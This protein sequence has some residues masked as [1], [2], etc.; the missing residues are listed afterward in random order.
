[1]HRIIARNL[2]RLAAVAAIAALSACMVTE[3]PAENTL[4]TSA[5][6]STKPHFTLHPETQFPKVG[7][8]FFFTVAA[9]GAGPITYQWQ[10]CLPG[11]SCV[12]MP[13]QTTT[14]L[15]LIARA[16]DDH[17]YRCLATNAF[18]TTAADMGI[19]GATPLVYQAEAAAFSG[20][21][22]FPINP[23]NPLGNRYVAFQHQSGDTITWRPAPA[24]AATYT[25][26]IRYSSA[27]PPAS[28]K[29]E[30]N[31]VVV[32]SALAFPPTAT[33]DT[34]STVRF[35]VKLKSGT[36]ILKATTLNWGGPHLDK[37]SVL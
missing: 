34:W 31:G 8:L 37:L 27:T 23:L 20:G 5:A 6:T 35:D 21:S 19:Y 12:D 24:S 7:D 1:M 15:F 25:L 3:N 10:K 22:S 36:N 13:G 11:P 16:E 4:A 9:T 18:G 28:M 33:W 2:P 30:L 14:S 17:G 29:I 26:E 32:K